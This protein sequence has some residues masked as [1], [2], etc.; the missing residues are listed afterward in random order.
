ML[1]HTFFLP[2]IYILVN[3]T[4]MR[5]IKKITTSEVHLKMK[6]PTSYPPYNQIYL[7]QIL[8]THAINRIFLCK[9]FRIVSTRSP[10]SPSASIRSIRSSSRGGG[11]SG[12]R[13]RGLVGPPLLGRSGCLATCSCGF[14]CGCF[15]V[16]PHDLCE[17][18]PLGIVSMH[19]SRVNC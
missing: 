7:C 14:G 6:M 10:H 15:F 1:Q 16:F 9:P 5:S 17:P 19:R 3:L 4:K 2:S 11:G 8:R 12:S 13:G 18:T